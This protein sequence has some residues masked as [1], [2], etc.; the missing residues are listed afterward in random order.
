MQHGPIG[1]IHI[2]KAAGSSINAVLRRFFLGNNMKLA[3]IFDYMHFADDFRWVHVISA[4]LPFFVF[5]AERPKRKL[6]TVLRDPTA[7]VISNY[8]YILAT[9]AHSAHHYVKN[10]GLSLAQCFD[11]PALKVEVTNFQTKMLGWSAR[12]PIRWPAH[13]RHESEV[14]FLEFANYVT[15]ECKGATLEAAISR[16]ENDITFALVDDPVGL[17]TLCRA[18]VPVDPGPTPRENETPKVAYQVTPA[19]HEAIITH[20]ALDFA[21]IDYARKRIKAP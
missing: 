5:E 2:P 18:M 1:F 13:E 8:N 19:D 6:F 4:H 14:A 17:A 10:K 12:Q 3:S 7:R 11:H 21:L 15:G 16:L 9:P 20:N